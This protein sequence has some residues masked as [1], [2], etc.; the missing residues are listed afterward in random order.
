MDTA[1]RPLTPNAN[2]AVGTGASPAPARVPALPPPQRVNEANAPARA[3]NAPARLRGGLAA[4]DSQLQDGVARA[5]QALD[6]LARL[7]AQLES[8]KGDLSA[9]LTG[10]RNARQ[11]EAHIRQLGGT[12]TA[13][14]K[15][16]GGGVDA[17]LGFEDGA[18]AQQ[19][20]RIRGLDL[21]ALKAAGTRTLALSV[22]G[23]PQVKVELDGDMSAAQVAQSFDRALAPLK[24]HASLDD[25]GQLVFSSAEA[26][27]PKVKDSI[28]LVGAGRVTTD[29]ID[30]NLKPQAWQA[31]NADALR[32]SLREVVQ[33]LARV[34]QSQ[35]AASAALSAA[36]ARMDQAKAPPPEQAQ[37]LAQQFADTAASPDYDSLISLTS[38]LVGVSRDRVIA[39][40]GTP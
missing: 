2:V 25:N 7:E 4:W 6:Y 31:G 34:R 21:A 12:L 13:R 38:A 27:W 9:R 17:Q 22:D 30:N 23:G 10:A 3:S 5:Q 8:V 1:L 28:V 20:F 26:D 24:L 32:Q 37:Q 14:G 15:Q 35:A 16:A 33:A 11:L 19:A 36:M 39:L 29:E 18:P 40:L